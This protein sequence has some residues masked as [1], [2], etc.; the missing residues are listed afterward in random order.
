MLSAVDIIQNKNAIDVFDKIYYITYIYGTVNTYK[1]Y[2]FK[3]HPNDLR[4][5]IITNLHAC[6]VDNMIII[7]RSTGK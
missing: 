1:Q 4:I 7:Y 2:A 3:Y 5:N 6:T